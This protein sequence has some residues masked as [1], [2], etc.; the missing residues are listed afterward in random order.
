MDT[1]I[2]RESA[3]SIFYVEETLPS[4]REVAACSL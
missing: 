2:S 1:N 4:G 3:V